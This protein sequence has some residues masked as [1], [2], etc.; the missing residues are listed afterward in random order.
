MDTI[1]TKRGQ[2]K[3]LKAACSEDYLLGVLK[4]LFS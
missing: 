3:H 1:K 2:D 4:G